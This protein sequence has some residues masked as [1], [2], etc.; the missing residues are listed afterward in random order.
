M[1]HSDFELPTEDIG[2]GAA[3]AISWDNLLGQIREALTAGDY[4]RA[5][6]LLRNGLEHF[7]DDNQLL[8]LAA[9]QR[10]LEERYT[11]VYSLLK[12]T[13]EAMEDDA[14]LR[15]VGAFR[16]AANLSQGFA[17]LEEAAFGVAV[18]EARKLGDRNWRVARS[19]FED[20]SRLNSKLVV[21]E[22]LWE[23]V[24]AA[25]REETIANVLAETALARPADLER[26]HTRLIRTLE[27]YPGDSGLL[28]RLKSIESTIEEKHKWDQRQR[29]LKKL[30]DLQAALQSEDEPS[31][32]GKYVRLSETVAAPYGA[33]PEFSSLI[34][35]I[36]HQAISCEKAAAALE[37]DR[38][39]DCLE[40]CAWVLSRMRHHKLFLKLKEKAEARELALVD[41]YSNTVSRIRELL[42]AGELAKAEK[43]CADARSKLPQF[44]D[45]LDLSREIEERKTE[46]DRNL[47]ENVESAR[48]LVERGDRSLRA[49]QYRATEESFANAFK[50]LPGD[51]NL[52]GVVLGILHGYARSVARESAEAAE[53][54]LSMAERLLPGAALPAD[55]R[56]VRRRRREQSTSDSN[57][58][59]ALNRI[60]DLNE[61]IQ[62]AATAELLSALR[63]EV[64]ASDFT[65]S[66]HPDVRFAAGALLSNIDEKLT[67]FTWNRERHPA[68]PRILSL[69]AAVMAVVGLAYWL[70]KPAS[71]KAPSKWV[72]VERTETKLAAVPK[73]AKGSLLIR[74]A[75]P[76]ALVLINGKEYKV[77]NEPLKVEL[78]A[79]TY[80]VSGSRKG[81]K[82][83]GPVTVAVGQSAET[84]L[85]VKLAPKPASLEIRGAASDTQIKLDGVLLGVAK[86]NTVWKK[87]LADGNHSIELSRNGYL[88]KTIVRNLAPGDLVVLTSRDVRLES[89]DALALASEQEEWNRLGGG[90]SLASIES[91]TAKYPK[92]PH[93]KAARAKVE[94][95]QWQN[96]DKS[97]P[98]SLRAYMT[99]YPA[100][101]F[102]NQARRVLDGLLMARE[103]KAEDGDWSN[104]NHGN[105]SALEDFL[106]KH[107]TGRHAAA[108][109]NA[110]AELERRKGVAEAQSRE[111]AAGK[112]V[113]Q[114]DEAALDTHFR[115]AATGRSRSDAEAAL[116]SLRS[117]E[118]S[119]NDSAAVLTVISRFASAWNT[120]DLNS[121]LAIQKT[122]NKRTVK[123]ELS[124]VKEL[125][126]RISPA[127]PPRIE[128]SQAVVLCR[129]QASQVFSDGTRKQIPES[130]V[131]Y[132]LEKHDGNWTI[133]G[134]R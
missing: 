1:Q 47:Q 21:P 127:S 128:G 123:A 117:N 116:A 6:N 75:V 101:P 132:V 65:S 90:A 53:E 92:G 33:E 20:A 99:K 73:P 57:R 130:L 96:V 72:T 125:N 109:A 37:Q 2:A 45:F 94:E 59:S 110:L 44:T 93:A 22:Q 129:R 63:E 18:D 82:D 106:R 111:E 28:N 122:L 71:V 108:A 48:R 55:L 25:E 91:F 80:R 126:M 16:E 134:T 62:L 29:H 98:D 131:S 46:Q 8:R 107:P 118:A 121:I 39:D 85:D 41:E 49:R 84:V 12:E 3:S 95:L 13:R 7:P 15:A 112:K 83:F 32:A 69:A 24:R 4:Q 50:L 36:R 120:R 38:I 9:R 78:N 102:A 43:L 23:A 64:L 81:Y 76:G 86:K 89:S 11:R 19:L 77:S 40:E 74:S 119:K 42:D 27:E 88:P 51:E 87:E 70:T 30:T 79:D 113:S 34:E 10:R 104:A 124:Q 60:A 14:F 56:E 115:D 61:Q 26:A 66:S 35:D 67:A 17:D 103:A 100:S 58:W 97:K 68:F 105:Q 5:G 133:E 114:Q 54:A 31:Q 52:A